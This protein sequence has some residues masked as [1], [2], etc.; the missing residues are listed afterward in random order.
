MRNF[1]YRQK[2]SDK[3][4]E[5]ATS[6]KPN[7]AGISS[8]EAKKVENEEINGCKFQHIADISIEF[9][10]RELLTACSYGKFRMTAQK[11]HFRRKSQHNGTETI[12]LYGKLHMAAVIRCLLLLQLF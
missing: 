5:Y 9:P 3:Q 2:I 4:A 11:H 10:Y 7:I 6:N 12:A 8:L 1:P